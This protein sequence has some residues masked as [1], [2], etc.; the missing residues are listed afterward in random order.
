[1]F[2]PTKCLFFGGKSV[3][4]WLEDFYFL[5]GKIETEMVVVVSWRLKLT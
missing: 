5:G 3:N 2:V 4:G 1:M